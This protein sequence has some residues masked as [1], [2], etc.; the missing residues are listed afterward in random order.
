[1]EKSRLQ[2]LRAIIL[3]L[4]KS[5]THFC[6]SPL[7]L[8]TAFKIHLMST[9]LKSA[10]IA[11]FKGQHIVTFSSME[12]NLPPQLTNWEDLDPF[13]VIISFQ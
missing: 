9:D 8:H 12:F 5:N 1:L 3:Q 11:I 7:Y 13:G 2:I 10:Q 6:N 4:Q